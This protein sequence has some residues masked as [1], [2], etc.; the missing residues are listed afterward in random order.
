MKKVVLLLPCSTIRDAFPALP[1]LT[2]RTTEDLTL[3]NRMTWVHVRSD[4][5]RAI[6]YDSDTETLGIEF[7]RGAVYHFFSVSGLVHE[8]FMSAPSHGK[9]YHRYIKKK[10]RFRLIRH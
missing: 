5:I 10:Y 9:F 4:A 3:Q 8:R 6:G 2:T 1:A 7:N